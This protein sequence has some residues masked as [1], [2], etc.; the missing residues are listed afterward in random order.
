MFGNKL[1]ELLKNGEEQPNGNNKKKI[2]NL[3]FFVVILIITVVAINII[4]NGSKTTNQQN[5]ND[6]SKKL[7]STEQVQT[8]T[9]VPNQGNTRVRRK[10]K[11]YTIKNPR[12]WGCRSMFELFGK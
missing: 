6:T 12:R 8:N 2:E 11:K 7:A 5:N 3:V 9:D 10:I 1:K 4:W